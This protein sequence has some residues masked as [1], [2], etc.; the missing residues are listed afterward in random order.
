MDK[1]AHVVI[2]ARALSEILKI[3]GAFGMVNVFSLSLLYKQ[4]IELPGVLDDVDVMGYSYQLVRPLDEPHVNSIVCGFSLIMIFMRFFYGS[5]IL[6]EGDYIQPDNK[7]NEIAVF[8]FFPVS[9]F[10]PLFA[11]MSCYAGLGEIVPFSVLLLILLTLDAFMMQITRMKTKHNRKHNSTSKYTS[12][13][14]AWS[15]I[16][17]STAVLVIILV[18][19]YGVP[20]NWDIGD[21]LDHMSS[22]PW[23]LYVV[24]GI[25]YMASLLDLKMHRPFYFGR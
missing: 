25:Y 17:G 4:K 19:V 3:L 2:V 12:E 6:L 24:N 22:D 21:S 10:L 23:S 5:I 11:I 20:Y 1:T 8:D 18:I 14:E 16:N 13:R 7:P 15:I 9:I